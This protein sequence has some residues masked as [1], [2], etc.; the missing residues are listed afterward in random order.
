[1]LGSLHDAE[2]LLQETL[3]AAWRGLSDFERRSSLRSWLY[4]IATNRCLNALRDAGRRPAAAGVP[5]VGG[6]HA[7]GP[8]TSPRSPGLSPIPTCCSRGSPTPR[9]VP[10]RATRPRRRSRW[11][12]S[13]GLQHLAPQQ[14]AVLVLRDVLGFRADEV[15]DDARH[16]R[17]PRSTVRCSAPRADL[18][19]ERRP[20]RRRARP[21]VGAAAAR[22]RAGRPL[23]RRVLNRRHRQRRRAAD[24]GRRR[25]DAA[26]ARV[27]PGPRGGRRVPA[28]PPV[29]P[30]GAVAVCARAGQRPARLGV[31]LASRRR[32]APAGM[33]VIAARADGIASITRFHDFAAD[34][35]VRRARAGSE[36]RGGWHRGFVA[37]PRVVDTDYR[38]RARSPPRRALR[39]RRAR[40]ARP[41]PRPI[42]PAPP[43]GTRRTRRCADGSAPR[44]RRRRQPVPARP[45][46]DP[47]HAPGP[48][49]AGQRP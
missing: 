35:P 8:R 10:R 43:V 45:R 13:S 14:R 40:T 1:M 18:S 20:R 38:E 31:L 22:V 2:D 30:P 34:G 12:S 47:E 27:A 5:R 11:P 6:G 16:Q 46:R 44:G 15:A 37:V 17:R 23:R 19:R 41:P 4:T 28:R 49:V 36:R 24:R 39:R 21:V 9:P 48:P 26:R 32:L 33:F 3:L 29:A 42:R 25:L 7:R